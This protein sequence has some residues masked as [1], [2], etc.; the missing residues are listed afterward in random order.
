V[1]SLGNSEAG[2]FQR[3]LLLLYR[4]RQLAAW[5]KTKCEVTA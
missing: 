3:N 4:W 1:Q 2:G 5:P